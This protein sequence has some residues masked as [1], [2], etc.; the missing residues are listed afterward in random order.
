MAMLPGATRTARVLV[1]VFALVTAGAVLA[2]CQSQFAGLRLTVA[3]GST[4]GEYYPLGTDMAGIWAE[5]L[6]ITRPA[7]LATDGTVDNVSRLRDGTADIGFASADAVGDPEQGARKLRALA[8]IYDDYIQIVVRA[9]SH[10]LRLSDL[11]GRRVSIGSAKSQVKVVATRLL[12]AAGVRTATEVEDSLNDSIRDFRAGRIDAFFWSGGLPT[13][14]INDLSK[15]LPIRLL[16]L[17]Q[18]TLDAMLAKY[19][20]YSAA[21]VPAGTYG[22]R[23]ASV[24]TITVP[25]F[26]LATDRMSDDVAQALVSSLFGATGTLVHDDPVALGIDVHNAIY[27]GSVPLHPGAEAYYRSAKI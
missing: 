12:G 2:G 18:G 19:P 17:D 3:A 1:L 22:G 9:D 4:D 8:R 21:V 25:N 23:N 24:T 6:G 11:A 27:T 26:L 10:I 20:V 13:K 5:Q 15:G 7:V 16:A 14:G